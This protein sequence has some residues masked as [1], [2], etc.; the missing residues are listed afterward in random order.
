MRA[1][2]ARGAL[3]SFLPGEVTQ[4]VVFGLGIG[5]GVIES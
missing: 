5:I 3:R 1:I 2:E 4:T